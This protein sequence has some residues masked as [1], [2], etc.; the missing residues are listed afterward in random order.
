MSRWLLRLKILGGNNRNF[1]L[2]FFVAHLEHLK[3]FG[4]VLPLSLQRVDIGL[5]RRGGLWW[6]RRYWGFGFCRAYSLGTRISSSWSASGI[7][8]LVGAMAFLPAAEAES[9]LDASRSLR[10]S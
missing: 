5:D 2:R 6:R 8:A 1:F 10:G 7:V 9:F 3:Y 4:F